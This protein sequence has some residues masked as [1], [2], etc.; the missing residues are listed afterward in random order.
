ML[1]CELGQAVNI[2]R[3]ERRHLLGDPGCP[4]RPACAPG[5]DRAGDHHRGRRGKNEAIDFRTG[6]HRFLNKLSVPCTLTET[7]SAG[8]CVA[9]FGLWSAPAWMTASIAKSRSA[10]R[11]SPRS[12]IE[13]TISVV[14]AG[15]GALP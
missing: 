12:A 13:P 4:H 9:I 11:T 8:R 14:D 3:Q 7:N 6:G 1:R 10:E 5:T 2:A 15:T